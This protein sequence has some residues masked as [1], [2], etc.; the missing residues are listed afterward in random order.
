[1]QTKHIVYCKYVPNITLGSRA[2][3]REKKMQTPHT[4]TVI[5]NHEPY[6]H[7]FSRKN[8]FFHSSRCFRYLLENRVFADNKLIQCLFKQHIFFANFPSQMCCCYCWLFDKNREITEKK[9][10]LLRVNLWPQSCFAL[11]VR[12]IERAYE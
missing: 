3:Q 12:A 10:V 11:C 7:R 2:H 6:Q 5:C 1:M 4:L 9:M 8:S